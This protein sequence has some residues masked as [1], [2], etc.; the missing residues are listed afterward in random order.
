MSREYKHAKIKDAKIKHA[1]I[2]D[3]EIKDAE[4]KKNIKKKGKRKKVIIVLLILLVLFLTLLAV[5]FGILKH[6]ISTTPEIDPNNIYSLLARTSVIYDDQGQLVKNIASNEHRTNVAIEIMPKN[7]IN[8]V[9]SIEDKTFYEHHGFN[10]VRLMG[11]IVD[12]ITGDERIGGT[13]TIT[14]Q[15]ARNLYLTSERSLIRKFREAY[16]TVQLEKALNKD[17]IM[18]AYLNTIY[19]GFNSYGVQTASQSYFSKN[20]EDLTLEECATLA[21]IP[22]NPSGYAPLKRF[23]SAN[24]TSDDPTIVLRSNTYTIIY[25]N[26]FVERQQQVL[27]LMLEQG[28]ISQEEYDLAVA[29]DMKTAMNPK[30]IAPVDV[31]SYFSDY[32]IKQVKKDLTEALDINEATAAEMLQSGGLKIYSTINANMQKITATEFEK[33]DNFP[34]V[35]GLDKDRSGNILDSKGNIILHNILNYFDPDGNFLLTPS[36]YGVDNDGNVIIYGGK[37]LNF[38]KTEVAGVRDYTIE[39]KNLYQIESGVFYVINGGNIIIDSKYKEKNDSG[40]LIIDKS[41]FKDQPDFFKFSGNGIYIEASQ[42]TLSQKAVQPQS[43]MVITDWKTGEIKAMMGGRN[44]TGSRLYNRAISPRQPGS[45]IKPIGVYGPALEPGAGEDSDWTAGSYL[46]DEPNYLDGKLWPENWYPGY[47]GYVTI[48]KSVE[49]SINITSVKLLE[50]IGLN[51]SIAFMKSLGITSIEEDDY[52]LAALGL[53]GMTRG[54]S[55]FE[56]AAAYG[57]FPNAGQFIE[58][59]CYSRVVDSE[60]NVIL[61][62]TVKT[63]QAMNRGVAFI[64]TDIL[65]TTVSKGIAK[66]ASI[67]G[68]PVAGKTGTTTDNYDAWFVGF[69][70]QYSA[71]LW[72]GNDLNVELSQGSNAA[73][74]LWSIIM[75]QICEGL[76]TGTYEMPDNVE[77]KYNEYYLAGTYKTRENPYPPPPPAPVI[78]PLTGP[79]ITDGAVTSEGGLVNP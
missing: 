28:M 16:Y 78:D 64:M 13:S 50:S 4:I 17:Q 29:V 51:K 2:T 46:H 71:A 52:N 57:A 59:I 3:A 32:L 30:Q 6:L 1:E 9:V 12:S 63:T 60:G 24:I 26:L 5:G 68:Q 10:Y 20:V 45:A 22:K 69:T 35:I 72:I 53:G 36:E 43:A 70:P 62:K 77:N 49:Q 8:A 37:R 7:L 18:E 61:E 31:Y 48:R 58:P 15:L 11:A 54:I 44:L 65:R 39:F 25:N 56:M 19:L 55:P 38:Y 67:E 23:N 74:R 47:K 79:A 41:F 76:P 66:G 40:D 73:T 34:R 14:Q 21:A 75:G 42:Y 27:G 33:N